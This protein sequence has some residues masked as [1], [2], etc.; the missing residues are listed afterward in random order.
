M[1]PYTLATKADQPLLALDLAITC[2][3]P[4]INCMRAPAP[5]HPGKV[6]R[7]YIGDHTI[8]SVAETLGVHRATL[9]RVLSGNSSISLDLAIRLGVAFG[10]S[11]D[12][13]VGLQLQHD[14]HKA[15]QI[16]RPK[17]Q[18]LFGVSVKDKSVRDLRGIFKA[19]R[20][21]KVSIADMR[22]SRAPSDIG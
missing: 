13:W 19:P 9:S 20:G 18:R 10:T 16:K 1:P 17:I 8:S 12:L 21:R 4:R 22:V 14:L 11:P 5:P 3:K 15:A 7:E 6:L 2:G